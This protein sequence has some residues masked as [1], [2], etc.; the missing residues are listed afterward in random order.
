MDGLVAQARELGVRSKC[1]AI[2][3][4][5]PTPREGGVLGNDAA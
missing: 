1:W 5:F 3:D 2:D 4:V